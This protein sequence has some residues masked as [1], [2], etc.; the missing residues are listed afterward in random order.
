MKNDL[1]PRDEDGEEGEE[2]EEVELVGDGCVAGSG[3]RIGTPWIVS[4]T[5]PPELLGVIGRM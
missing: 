4:S 1:R 2:E 3:I 5:W